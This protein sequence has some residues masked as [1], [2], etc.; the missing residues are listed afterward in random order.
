MRNGT[1]ELKIIIYVALFTLSIIGF[2]RYQLSASIQEQITHA[3]AARYDL[4][5]DTVTPIVT[6]N[7]SM[8][9]AD[10]N[11]EYL[12][13]IAARNGDIRSIDLTDASQRQLYRFDR[14]NPSS[15]SAEHSRINSSSRV[16]ID[17]YSK[18]AL[19]TITIDFSAQELERIEEHYRTIALSTLLIS[20]AAAAVFLLLLKREFRRLRQLSES[21]LAYDPAEKRDFPVRASTKKDEVGV[22]QNA[23]I[24][25]VHRLNRYAQELDDTNKHLEQKVHQRTREL[26]EANR[27]LEQLSVTDPLTGLPNRRHFSQRYEQLW[28]TA[29]RNQTPLSLILCDIDHFK[30]INDTY[31]HPVGDI[32]LTQ[33][34]ALLQNALKRSTDFVAR[35]GGE[36][37]IILLPDADTD[38]A[39]ALCTRIRQKMQTLHTSVE[40]LEPPQNITFSFGIASVI[41]TAELSAESAIKEADAALYQAKESGRDTV[42]TRHL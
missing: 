25:M 31:G 40:G 26:E 5:A 38:K 32:V 22:I 9:L 33:T 34:G 13:E 17:P 7:L 11:K 41:P 3:E 27:Q 16:M 14:D 4:L 8:G 21:V 19:G 20:L 10:A 36:E 24:K 30:Q 6:L 18:D 12:D 35:Y 15:T 23:I 1:L 42:T 29:R 37:F 39:R 2:Q 28:E